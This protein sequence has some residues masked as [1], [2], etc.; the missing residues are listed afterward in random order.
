MPGFKDQ[1]LHLARLLGL[2]PQDFDAVGIYAWPAVLHK[3]EKTFVQKTNANTH[4]NWWWESFQKPQY[5]L[6]LEEGRAYG[7]LDQVLPPHQRVWFV[8]CDSGHD[9][10]KFWLFQGSVTAIQHL[11]DEHSA[12]EYYVVS[13]KYAWLLCETHHHLLIGLGNVIPKLQAL[14]LDPRRAGLLE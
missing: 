4:F 2:S 8:A 9:P 14:A 11:L 3:I 6:R 10:S 7:C 13:K 5:S 1:L 12:F